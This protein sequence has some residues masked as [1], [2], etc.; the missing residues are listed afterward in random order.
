MG[1]DKMPATARRSS[2]LHEA[3]RAASKSINATSAGWSVGGKYADPG[4]G[5]VSAWMP[6]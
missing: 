2:S 5:A 6:R 4:G 3:A 1:V